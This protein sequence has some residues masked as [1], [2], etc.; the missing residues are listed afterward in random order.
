MSPK[1]M[2]SWHFA[3]LLSVSGSFTACTSSKKSHNPPAA[4][5]DKWTIP[6]PLPTLPKPTPN[7]ITT[8]APGPTGATETP[9]ST[10]TGTY[11]STPPPS[12]I[13][14][15]Q[16][17]LNDYNYA[18]DVTYSIKPDGKVLISLLIYGKGKNRLQAERR[19]FTA[20]F[21]NSRHLMKLIHVK[22]T[23]ASKSLETVINYVSY[24]TETDAIHFNELY[25]SNSLRLHL[26]KG[27]LTRDVHTVQDIRGHT[28]EEGCFSDGRLDQFV[29]VATRGQS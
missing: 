15:W 7:P 10:S 16:S 4:T 26:I 20:T 9:G 19:A 23:C 5:P 22:G 17:S 28:I 13:G 29:P 8:P 14:N 24:P 12:L 27:G 25:S 21:N 11:S 18:G 3:F 1:L 6:S 2:I